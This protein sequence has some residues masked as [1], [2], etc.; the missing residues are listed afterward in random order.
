[1]ETAR[2][3]DLDFEV[4]GPPQ[5]IHFDV[6]TPVGSEILRSQD[7]TISLEN[8]SYKIGQKIVAQKYRFVGLENGQVGLE[9]VGHL[10][11][12]CYIPTVK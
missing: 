6:K 9:N 7:Q 4:E 8:M 12:L 11:D 1:M 5:F 3:V 10:A 2:L